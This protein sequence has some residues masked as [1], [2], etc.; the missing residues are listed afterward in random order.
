M[1][2]LDPAACKSDGLGL[3]HGLML[4]LLGRFHCLPSAPLQDL[5]H[6][7]QILN[8]LLLLGIHSTKVLDRMQP[9]AFP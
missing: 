5:S 7:M 3:S 8:L 1:S 9:F 6:F 4:S 2:G